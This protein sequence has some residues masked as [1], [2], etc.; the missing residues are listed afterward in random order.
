[1]EGEHKL[2]IRLMD[3]GISM[4]EWFVDAAAAFGLVVFIGSAFLLAE[5]APVVL[6]T[7]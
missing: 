7:F 2:N 4:R 3:G 5:V 1:M 6:H